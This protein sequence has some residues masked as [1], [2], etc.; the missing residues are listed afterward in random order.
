M[1]N[2]LSDV[3]SVAEGGIRTNT[4]SQIKITIM[5]NYLQFHVGECFLQLCSEY[6]FP[7]L[8]SINI[9]MKT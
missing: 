7:R 3:K 8:L 5:K 1:C 2:K 9:K 4:G 6:Y